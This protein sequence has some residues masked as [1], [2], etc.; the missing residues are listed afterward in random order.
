MHMNIMTAC[1]RCAGCRPVGQLRPPSSR[2]RWWSGT[3][4]TSTR[5]STGCPSRSTVRRQRV[6]RVLQLSLCGML[7]DRSDRATSR[8]KSLLQDRHVTLLAEV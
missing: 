8:N 3:V 5:S 7:S 4:R 1:V 6:A 2:S